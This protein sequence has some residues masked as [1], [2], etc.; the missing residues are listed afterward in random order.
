MHVC[1][2]IFVGCV[3]EPMHLIRIDLHV[4]GLTDQPVEYS[5]S[6]VTL[7]Y[8]IQMLVYEGLNVLRNGREISYTKVQ[9]EC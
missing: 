8:Y 7:Q 9:E 4:T 2:Y 5:Y 6:F 3:S 1:T